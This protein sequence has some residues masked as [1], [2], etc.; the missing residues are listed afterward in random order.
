MTGKYIVEIHDGHQWIR[1]SW[2]VNRENAINVYL[3]KEESGSK[4][5]LVFDGKIIQASE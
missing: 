3:V 4:V 1:H 5:R 2:H